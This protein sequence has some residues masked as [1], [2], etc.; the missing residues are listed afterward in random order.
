MADFGGA[1]CVWMHLPHY[2]NSATNVLHLIKPGSYS[3]ILGRRRRKKAD[4]GDIFGHGP[5]HGLMTKDCLR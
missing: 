1:L 5:R 3:A 4:R 2:D